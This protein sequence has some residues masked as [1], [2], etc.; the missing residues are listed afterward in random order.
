MLWINLFHWIF[1]VQW[2]IF[3][4]KIKNKYLIL[5]VL[6][7]TLLYTF[8]NVKDYFTV[9]WLVLLLSAVLTSSGRLSW[10]NTFY[11]VPVWI[12]YK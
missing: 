7:M 8:A 6:V 10:S 4:V 5:V 2:F 1:G 9:R 11:R 12:I 3:V